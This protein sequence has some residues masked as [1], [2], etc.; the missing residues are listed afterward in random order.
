[1][2]IKDWV[3]KSFHHQDTTST[4]TINNRQYQTATKVNIESDHNQ[5]KGA[6]NLKKVAGIQG[7]FEAETKKLQDD[8]G[9]N[10]TNKYSNIF[11]DMME[12][13]ITKCSNN[14]FKEQSESSNED[15]INNSLA[16]IGM[17]LAIGDPV[18]CGEFKPSNLVLHNI[19][20]HI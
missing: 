4:H 1:M 10:T 7:R 6:Q 17:P 2:T 18:W 12:T 20:T 9:H 15:S 5:L 19:L 16:I 11:K 13:G 3:T 8:N 14:S